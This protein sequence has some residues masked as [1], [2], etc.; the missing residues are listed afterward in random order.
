M[1]FSGLFEGQDGEDYIATVPKANKA[2]TRG[3]V[4][5]FMQTQSLHGVV[6]AIGQQ[7]PATVAQ[8]DADKADITV[9]GTFTYA[10][11]STAR[12]MTVANVD[13]GYSG[14]SRARVAN[15]TAAELDDTF[16]TEL[17][18]GFVADEAE[19]GVTSPAVTGADAT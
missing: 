8:V 12:D 6:N 17:K 9:P 1:S 2:P 14:E 19:T 4:R 13:P 16:D 15:A 18:E 11:R 5:R 7:S 10:T 3:I